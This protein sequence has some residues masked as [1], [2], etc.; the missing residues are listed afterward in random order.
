M[1]SIEVMCPKALIH[2]CRPRRGAFHYCT[3]TPASV[4]SI[5]T[6]RTHD[7]SVV[8]IKAKC[9]CNRPI[10]NNSYPVITPSVKKAMRVRHDYGPT[11]PSSNAIQELPILSHPPEPK[12]HFLKAMPK[13][14][15]A[16]RP[17]QPR[18][19][20]EW[21]ELV[22]KVE[23]AKRTRCRRQPHARVASC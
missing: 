17:I 7:C 10:I 5:P 4:K 22:V 14:K 20:V 16:S 13:A 21:S 19:V 8:A 23:K 12:C 9:A 1:K 11:L 6:T 3:I 2:A 18:T 15:R